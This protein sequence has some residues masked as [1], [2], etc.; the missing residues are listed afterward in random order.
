MGELQ[1]KE[2]LM[3]KA[4]ILEVDHPLEE[5]PEVRAPGISSLCHSH[6]PNQNQ[7]EALSESPAAPVFE[8]QKDLKNGKDKWIVPLVYAPIQSCSNYQN[9]GT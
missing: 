2:L 1:T 5:A 7:V 9:A 3:V 6:R 4:V 8:A